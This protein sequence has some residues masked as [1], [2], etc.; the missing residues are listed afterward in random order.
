MFG[1]YANVENMPKSAS[2]NVADAHHRSKPRKRL[3]LK[4]KRGLLR[5][6]NKMSAQNASFH[7]KLIT[8]RIERQEALN[9]RKGELLMLKKVLRTPFKKMYLLFQTFNAIVGPVNIYDSGSLPLLFKWCR[10]MYLCACVLLRMHLWIHM[11]FRPS[12]TLM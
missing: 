12:K 5:L 10:Q 11:H 2:S 9:H 1:Q 6:Q 4:Y 8:R 7:D 3:Q